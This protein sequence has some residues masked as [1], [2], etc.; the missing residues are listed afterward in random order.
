M[1]WIWYLII[2]WVSLTIAILSVIRLVNKEHYI[3]HIDT[4]SK[5]TS[6]YDIIRINTPISQ[7]P[8]RCLIRK[9]K[10]NLYR[11]QW[12]QKNPQHNQES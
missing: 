4:I 6:C 10:T 5:D 2:V 1:K 12:W 3:D 11:L 9:K 7:T 8:T